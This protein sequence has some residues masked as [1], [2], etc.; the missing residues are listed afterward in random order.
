MNIYLQLFLIAVVVVYVVDVSGFTA[1]WRHALARRLGYEDDDELR[2]L[3]PFDCGKCMTWW[4]TVIFTIAAGH[5][6]LLTLAACALL[7]MLS[8]TINAL[9]LFIH[10]TLGYIIDK[11]TPRT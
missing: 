4:A 6:S 8:D 1:S 3:P 5:F 7:S 2:P 11:I 9:L 10:E